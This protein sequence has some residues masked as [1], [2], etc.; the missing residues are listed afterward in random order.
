M[1][2]IGSAILSFTCENP[3]RGIN[4]RRLL[5]MEFIINNRSLGFM[6]SR[7]YGQ[8]NPLSKYVRVN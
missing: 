7:K 1:E 4:N 5:K 6:C 2:N 3:I 8:I